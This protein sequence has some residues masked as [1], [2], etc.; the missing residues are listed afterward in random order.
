MAELLPGWCTG[1]LTADRGCAETHLLAPLTR[2]G[3][4]GRIRIK[5]RL[6]SDRQG[7]R[8]CHV[9]RLPGAVGQAGFWRAIALPQKCY[10]PV[11]LALGRPH[12][13]QESGLV[14]RDE[15]T[16]T[17]TFEAY[18]R[19]FD[20]EANFWADQSHGF[21]LESSL[22]RSATARER[23]CGVWAITTLSLVSQGAEVV[24]PGQRRWVDA[25]GGRGRSDLKIGWRWVTRA[26]RRGYALTTSVRVAAEAD[27]EP[28]MASTIPQQKQPPLFFALACQDAVA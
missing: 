1:G 12:G 14:L 4:H 23:R 22:I 25:H 2:W 24:T 20:S 3:G 8:R 11:H 19:R 26:L 16:E 10:G 13:S 6:G 15:P 21:P 7:K 5:G 17:K 18:G 9:N 27:P 28:A